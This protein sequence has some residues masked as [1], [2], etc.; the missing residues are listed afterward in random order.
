MSVWWYRIIRIMQRAIGRY[1]E[2]EYEWSDFESRG[3]AGKRLET[4]DCPSILS[5]QMI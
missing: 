2:A 1:R 4:R 5:Q 3:L